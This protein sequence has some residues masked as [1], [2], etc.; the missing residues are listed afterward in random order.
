MNY[1]VDMNNIIKQTLRQNID[2]IGVFAFMLCVFSYIMFAA[3]MES[4]LPAHANIAKDM[5][6]T[7]SLLTA[8]FL[9]YFLVNLL[10]L[11]SGH[12]GSMRIALVLLISLANTAKY[13]IV[14]EAF[15][16]WTSTTKA[17]LAAAALLV[18]Y[19]IPLMY[20]LKPLGF[21][22]S[23]NNMYLGYYV[24]NVWHNS[25]ILC[26]MPFAVACYL[27]SVK[28]FEEYSDLRNLYITIL[29]AIS[30]LIKPSFYFV[31]VIAYPIIII[32]RYGFVK[33]TFRS[34]IPLLIGGICLTYEY[35]TIYYHGG[36][37]GSGVVIDIMQLFTL[38]FWKSH[39]LYLAVSILLPILFLCLYARTV[40]KDREFWFVLIMLICAL[41]IYW[42]CQ[43]T[44]PRAGHGNLGWQVIAT[45]WLTYFYILKN[46]T[47]GCEGW[48]SQ[49]R[50]GYSHRIILTAL[51]LHTI[52]G[53]IYLAKFI[54]T[55]S[56][57]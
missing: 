17:K 32:N 23:A 34:I 20:F 27:L 12:L 8:N 6:E 13:I 5:L 38:N 2:A 53:I 43:E 45:M 50:G 22:P 49:N 48:K 4:D 55:N 41:G 28:Q 15:K 47:V 57:R 3:N 29:L 52:M 40:Y 14:R 42:C 46:I 7:N 11:F 56:F 21:F 18:V 51:F 35:M 1:S 19:V 37:D 54:L 26:M 16:Q 44:G 9:M 39:A 36:N 10:T 31:Y 30:V 25:T 33:E 24:P